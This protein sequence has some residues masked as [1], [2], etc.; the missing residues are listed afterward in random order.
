[1]ENCEVI[2]EVRPSQVWA[3]LL[4]VLGIVLS[5]CQAQEPPLSP[6]AAA[7]KKE[8]KDC[9]AELSKGLLQPVSQENVPAIQEALQKI[10][11]AAAKLCRRCP[12]RIGVL[13]KNGDTLTIYPSKAEALDFSNYNVVVQTLKTRRIMQ[14][15]FYL[16][17]GSQVF[18]VCAPLLRGDDLLGILAISLSAAEANSRWGVTEKEFMAI[19]FNR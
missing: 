11:P 7:F 9:L 17:D 14:Q 19:D 2:R 16:Q 6:A 12:F 13:N 10:E 5:G 4:L 15:R 1:M 8:V 18:I 3:V